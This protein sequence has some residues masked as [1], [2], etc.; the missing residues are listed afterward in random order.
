MF[1]VSALHK[2]FVA[3][4]ERNVRRI[5]VIHFAP[6]EL[7]FFGTF[8]IYKHLAPPE[9]KSLVAARLRCISVVKKPP[10]TALPQEKQRAQRLHREEG[11]LIIENLQQRLALVRFTRET[12]CPV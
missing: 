2:V 3:P 9:L 10:A 6:A 12:L 4:E 11:K 7:V 1:I 5:L 8:R